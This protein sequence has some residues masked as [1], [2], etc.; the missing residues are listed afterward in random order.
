MR[1]FAQSVVETVRHPLVVL[2]AGLRV[3]RANRVF[4]Q[5]F[6]VADDQAAGVW[7]LTPRRP[8]ASIT[9][10]KVAAGGQPAFFV[11]DHGAGC[12]PAFAGKLLAPYQRLHGGRVWAEGAPGQGAAFYFTLPQGGD[13]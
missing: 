13:A 5:T 7:K 2:D 1:A 8:R 3:R 9:R 11:R 10:G 12:N 6:R 4:C